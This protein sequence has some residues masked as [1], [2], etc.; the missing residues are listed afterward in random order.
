MP[1][2]L[3]VCCLSAVHDALALT[4]LD[5]TSVAV[6][7]CVLATFLLSP[8][9]E[10]RIEL[11]SDLGD[12]REHAEFGPPVG[13]HVPPP[14]QPDRLIRPSQCCRPRPEPTV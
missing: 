8:T 7:N 2:A 14:P 9:R 12:L 10:G 5:S 1:V 13:D 3:L 4:H 11:R 6:P